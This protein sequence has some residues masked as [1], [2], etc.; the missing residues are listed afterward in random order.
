ML[1]VHPELHQEKWL[2][3]PDQSQIITNIKSLINCLPLLSWSEY[4]KI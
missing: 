1:N 2:P 4:D 3:K